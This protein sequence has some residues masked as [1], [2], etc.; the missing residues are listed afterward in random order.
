[1]ENL[2]KLRIR[3]AKQKIVSKT[4]KIFQEHLARITIIV[5]LLFVVWVGIHIKFG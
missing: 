1:M 2:E 3:L 5:L 4:K